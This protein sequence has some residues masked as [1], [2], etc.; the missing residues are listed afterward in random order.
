MR[1]GNLV[2]IMFGLALT[3]MAGASTASAS[4][5]YVV[6]NE[7]PSDAQMPDWTRQYSVTQA[8]RCVFETETN[9]PAGN[10][11]GDNDEA[12]TYLN[13]ATGWGTGWVGLGQEGPNS[14]DILGFSYVADGQNDD[15]TFTIGAL[16]T[17]QYGQFA[18][19]IKDGDAPKWA[20]FLLPA[21]TFSGDW[22]FLTEGGD[23][24]HFALFGRGTPGTID[25][26]LLAAPEPATLA[27]LGLGLAA[28][29]RR[30]RRKN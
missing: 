27:L 4:P 8:T 29:A 22:H 23:L 12:N 28:G 15:G 9:G 26:Q 10:I 2:L 30:L 3:G 20:I 14:G 25:E 17:A 21:G 5:I 7:C 1:K 13:G 11:Q 6:G 18:L 24:S 16:L 19:G